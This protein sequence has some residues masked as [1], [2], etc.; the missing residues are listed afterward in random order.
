M[1]KLFPEITDFFSSFEVLQ[2]IHHQCPSPGGFQTLHHLIGQFPVEIFRNLQFGQACEQAR[3]G[4]P[5]PTFSTG[6]VKKYFCGEFSS[7]GESISGQKWL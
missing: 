6:A 5:N 4:G 2:L 7:E 3:A 1:R